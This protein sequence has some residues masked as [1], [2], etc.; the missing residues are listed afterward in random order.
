MLNLFRRHTRTCP[1]RSKGRPYTK[2]NCPL[3]VDGI[4][5]NDPIPQQSLGTRNWQLAQEKVLTMEVNAFRGVTEKEDITI[6]YAID[7][8]KADAKARN[9]D[10]NT[11]KKMRQ[12]TD[13]LTAF[14]TDRG[15]SYLRQLE[16]PD[17]TAEF[18]E[19]WTT[20]TSRTAKPMFER[21]RSFFHF[22]VARKWIDSNPAA[23]LKPPKV[24]DRPT[25][26]FTEGP[27]S[28]ME[29]ILFACD[30][31][32]TSGRYRSNNRKRMRAMVLLQRWSG[33]AIMDACTLERSRLGD[34]NRLLLRRAK[35]GEPVYVKLP[36]LVADELRVLESPHADYFFWTGKGS[37]E[38]AVKCWEDAYRTLFGIAGIEE[39][40]SH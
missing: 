16:S 35:T 6:E 36:P 31:Y 7:R 37:E 24:E 13:K 15:F 11:I 12:L 28:E 1:Y 23:A 8:W 30:I 20:W 2:C 5:G 3:A 26:P 4:L 38:T 32:N 17:T 9:L 39:G 18:R 40:H 27:G 25:L 21:L 19:T 29:R 14:C 22:C 34:D 10:E 33:L